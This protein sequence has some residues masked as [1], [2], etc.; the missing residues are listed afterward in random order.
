[1]FINIFIFTTSNQYLILLHVRYLTILPRL[2]LLLTLL[3]T[4]FTVRAQNSGRWSELASEF[5][6]VKKIKLFYDESSLEKLNELAKLLGNN[7]E[8]DVFLKKLE[9]QGLSV[10]IFSTNQWVIAAKKD[11]KTSLAVWQER[12]RLVQ[13]QAEIER[14]KTVINIG[15]SG[16]ASSASLVTV[17]GKI[18]DKLN[19]IPVIGA[20]V[21]YIGGSN[22]SATDAD[23][24]Y[25]ILVPKG[26][27]QLVFKS[28][29]M[30][31]RVVD[32]MVYSP[33]KLDIEMEEEA[34]NLEEVVVTERAKDDNIKRV[35]MGVEQLAL[36]EIKK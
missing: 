34:I 22:G 24:A 13:Q 12:E 1:M 4:S 25:S 29:G 18:Q 8:Q 33:G 19:G 23:G 2:I 30:V 28:L 10:I 5:E 6:Q 16:E 14:Q 35:Q 17:S 21:E 11:T 26:S 7:P 20:T 27:H 31:N 32:V 3:T 15:S 9:D 36:K